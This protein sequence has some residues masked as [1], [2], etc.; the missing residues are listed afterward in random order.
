MNQHVQQVLARALFEMFLEEGGE[1][2]MTP[3][4]GRAFIE[5]MVNK[6]YDLAPALRGAKLVTDMHK[7][8]IELKNWMFSIRLDEDMPGLS[9]EAQALLV[10][11]FRSETPDKMRKLLA[12][13]ARW[14]CGDGK[15]EE[16][17]TPSA[18]ALQWLDK[19]PLDILKNV[20]I[21]NPDLPI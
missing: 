5:V 3:E 8:A 4:Y 9:Q 15:M 7:T 16:P 1:P 11:L 19:S 10:A 21:L 2:E 6:M 18:D 13:G 14:A 12:K 17:V 20:G